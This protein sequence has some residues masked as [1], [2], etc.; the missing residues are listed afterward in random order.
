MTFLPMLVLAVAAGTPGVE[1]DCTTRWLNEEA[2]SAQRTRACRD[3]W[4]TVPYGK[5]FSD[6][7]LEYDP[8]H[9]L[10]RAEAFTAVQLERARRHVGDACKD[11]CT[12][13]DERAMEY[14]SGEIRAR[15]ELMDSQGVS[16]ASYLKQ[17]L[18]GE[19]LSQPKG[20]PAL[21]YFSKRVL[22]KLRN[23]VF[24][25]HGRPFKDADLQAFFYGPRR[26]DWLEAGLPKLSPDERFSEAR[27]TAIDRQNLAHLDSVLSKKQ[28]D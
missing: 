3:W 25:R 5:D 27:L 22:R 20:G 19:P 9:P 16:I 1:A 17:L 28:G 10:P 13:R 6:A 7:S 23:A 2:P 15:L 24:A 18:A 26:E 8:N 14:F 12:T 4:L 21:T 11:R